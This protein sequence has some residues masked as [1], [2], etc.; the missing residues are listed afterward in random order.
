M[1]ENSFNNRVRHKML[2]TLLLPVYRLW[3][4]RAA[5]HRPA[6]A[7]GGGQRL[8]VCER[9]EDATGQ[10]FT[11]TSAWYWAAVIRQSQGPW[12][13]LTVASAL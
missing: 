3:P 7:P 9:I 6:G 4:A 11:D 8:R 1:L 10:G 13:A 2:W 5:P 12:Q